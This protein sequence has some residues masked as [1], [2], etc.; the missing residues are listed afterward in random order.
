MYWSMFLILIV[1]FVTG[2]EVA[3]DT[4]LSMICHRLKRFEF[5]FK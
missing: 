3:D 4:F 5:T 1:A 2:A